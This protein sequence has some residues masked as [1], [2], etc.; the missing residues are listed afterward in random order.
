VGN[1]ELKSTVAVGSG[2]GLAVGDA[3][4]LAELSGVPNGVGVWTAGWKGVAVGEAF[5][6]AVTSTRG[7]G[8][9]LVDGTPRQPPKV[10]SAR[11][12]R[13]RTPNPV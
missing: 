8:R 10:I 5:G 12:V 3:V 4:S 11:D 2:L 9:G 7:A 6:A 1:S 13:P